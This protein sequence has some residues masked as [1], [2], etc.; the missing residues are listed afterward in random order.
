[1]QE[2]ERFD[3]KGELFNT[4]EGDMRATREQLT[5]VRAKQVHVNGWDVQAET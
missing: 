1:M 5:S 2:G 4:K 3:V